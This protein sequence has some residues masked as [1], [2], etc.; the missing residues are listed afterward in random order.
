LVAQAREALRLAQA[1]YRFQL[2]SFVELTSAE[3]AASNA[4]AQYAQARYKYK[5]A[6]AKLNYVA[7]RKYTP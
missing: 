4:E 2:G 6:E 1:R 7:G 5:L 3:A